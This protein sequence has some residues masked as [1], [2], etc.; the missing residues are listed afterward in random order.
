MPLL[1][2]E[3]IA[4]RLAKLP[5]WKIE[6]GLLTKVY[7]VRSFAHGVLFIGAIGQ[8]AEAANHH[9]DVSL[10]GYNRV[11]LRL[12]THSE[13]GLTDKDFDL[14]EQIES[15]PQRRPKELG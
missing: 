8:L 4:E 1:A 2:S 6:N 14:A 9:P 11:T 15:L 12:S 7:T 3:Q 5:G 13:G 10:H